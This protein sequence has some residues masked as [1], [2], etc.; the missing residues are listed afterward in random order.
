MKTPI[1]LLKQ[2]Q[3]EILRKEV[4]SIKAFLSY[5]DLLVSQEVD[6]HFIEDSEESY[7]T[8]FFNNN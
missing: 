7:I 4:M 1:K 2:A 6:A 3:E 5:F 8:Y